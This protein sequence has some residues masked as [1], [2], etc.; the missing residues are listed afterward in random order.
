MV[1]F[2]QPLV[3]SVVLLTLNLPL[4]DASYHTIFVLLC[5]AYFT[6][7]HDFKVHLY[8]VSEVHFMQN[9]V[10]IAYILFIHLLMDSWV[11]SHLLI[12]VNNADLNICDL[13]FRS[14]WY[15]L[16]NGIAESLGHSLLNFLR[17]HHTIF[18]SDCTILCSH[19]QGTSLPISSRLCQCLLFSVFLIMAFLVD[20]K[21]YLVVRVCVSFP[22]D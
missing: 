19:Y 2:P 4:L 22:N 3:T 16:R 5:L 11:S 20:V 21:Q 10:C 17:D 1:S 12:F 9:N 7:H 8:Y 6:Q 14:F 15:I 13:V 18:H